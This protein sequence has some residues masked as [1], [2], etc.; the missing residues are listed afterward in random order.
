MF[1]EDFGTKILHVGNRGFWDGGDLAE[2]VGY[3]LI[4]ACNKMGFML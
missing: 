2:F 4:R 3:Y 1:T